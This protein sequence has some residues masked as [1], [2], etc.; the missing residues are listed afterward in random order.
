MK[1][2]ILDFPKQFSFEPVVENKRFLK[3]KK[4]LIVAG[5]GGS[6]LAADLLKIFRPELDL[7]IHHDYSL[8]S[9]P[10]NTYKD[11]LLIASSYSGN[12]EET[13]DA[14]HEARKLKMACT[15]IAVGGKLL[16]IAKKEKLAYI[17]LPH[18]G[19]QPRSALGYSF[20]AMLK[21]I[22]DEAGL[23]ESAKLTT[24]L[25]AKSLEVS[26]REIAGVLRDHVPVIYSSLKNY[27]IAYNWKIKLNE[28]GKIPAFANTFPELN[29]NEM[30]GFDVQETSRHLSD[31]FIFVLLKDSTDHPRI[32][33]RMNILEGLYRG[34]NLPVKP[35]FLSGKNVLEKTFSALLLA[36]WT[37]FY[38]ASN[39]GLD[40][41]QVPMVEEFKKLMK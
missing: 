11:Y 36:D 19:I 15:V 26:G 9:L 1:N 27:P 14:L 16:E 21:L 3:K 6:H 28:T 40:P 8:P 5:M 20:R 39:Y 29:H 41:E 23:R 31:K 12:T 2:A 37:A 13:L 24:A 38:T 33:K 35:I 18:T 17:Q 32:A 4:R 10:K 34:R 25:K 30:T 22:G 7:T